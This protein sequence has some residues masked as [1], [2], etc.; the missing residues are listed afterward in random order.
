MFFKIPDRSDTDL[1][2]ILDRVRMGVKYNRI[3][4][5]YSISS[6]KIKKLVKTFDNC[7]TIDDIKN[8]RVILLKEREDRILLKPKRQIDHREHY[9]KYRDYYRNY[10]SS[11]KK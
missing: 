5:D 11:Y 10:Y 4:S 6:Y 3:L 1:L 2:A 9:R 8:K 7:Y